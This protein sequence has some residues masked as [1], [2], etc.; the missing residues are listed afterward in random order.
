MCVCVCED[1]KLGSKH[2]LCE[3]FLTTVQLLV[4]GSNAHDDVM[5]GNIHV[6]YNQSITRQIQGIKY[7]LL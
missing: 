4:Q 3:K 6:A 1:I 7:G 5:H 2:S